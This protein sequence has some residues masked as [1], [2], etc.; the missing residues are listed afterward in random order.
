[1][2]RHKLTDRQIKSLGSGKYDDGDGLRLYVTS[3]SAKRWVF[4]YTW[5]DKRPE[6]GLGSYPVV[7]LAQARE[8]AETYRQYLTQGKDPKIIKSQLKSKNNAIP[9]FQKYAEQFMTTYSPT[10]GKVSESQWRNTIEQYATPVI[11]QTPVSEVSVEQVLTVLKPIWYRIP[12]TAKRLQGRLERIFEAAISE[13]YRKTPNP[14]RWKGH[15][16]HLLPLR[17]SKRAVRHHPALPYSDLPAFVDELIGK[18][19]PASLALQT[20]ILT[21]SRTSDVLQAQWTEIDITHRLWTIPKGRTKTKL[22]DHRIPIS[23]AL[24]NVLERAS[25]FRGSEFVFP[26]HRHG[27][28]LSNMSLLKIMR[29]MGYGCTE[30]C[31]RG[32]AVPHGFRSTFRD[33]AG[34]TTSYPGDVIEMALAHEIKNKVEAAYR[35]GDLLDKRRDLMEDWAKFAC[36]FEGESNG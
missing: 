30:G 18:T 11:G 5:G 17:D 20:L 29:S 6:I 4:R 8:L 12:E 10:W 7:S 28:P 14:A 32:D 27:R 24:A 15:I 16:A 13:E 22:R 33:W 25:E 9:T 23:N 35:R 1:M 3:S 34:E 2:A 21:A 26:G 36:S 19:S 31:S